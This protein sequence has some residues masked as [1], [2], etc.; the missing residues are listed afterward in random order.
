MRQSDREMEER[1]SE[2][3][4]LVV[5]D[6]ADI[7]EIVSFHLERQGY[8]T[9]SAS[10]AEE[11][12][13]LIKS[14]SGDRGY[15][16]ILLDVMM[17]GMTGFE[18][19]EELREEGDQVPIIFLTARSGEEDLLKGFTVGG[20]DYISKP[21]SVKELVARVK[22]VLR[23]SG[24][25]EQEREEQEQITVGPLVIDEQAMTVSDG[26]QFFEVT[27]TEYDLLRMLASAPGRTYTRQEILDRVW[28]RQ[29]LVLDRTV[30]V[31]V[32]RLRKKLGKY[33]VMLFNRVGFGYGLRPMTM[34]EI[35]QETESA[36][37]EEKPHKKEHK[38][39]KKKKS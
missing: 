5:D 2:A 4:I 38:G 12:L 11:A 35:E 13:R 36:P 23:R 32:A 20:D 31:H 34:E 39:K 17:E 25:T 10:S 9:S 28:S 27:K 8:Y 29:S 33:G 18:M 19:A 6:E 7:C 1:S 37:E 21:F 24:A 14:S 22:S 26:R 16:L 30:D 15:D 3:R